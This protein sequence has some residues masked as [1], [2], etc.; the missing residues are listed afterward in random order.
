MT[1]PRILPLLLQAKITRFPKM[2]HLATLNHLD[3]WTPDAKA[4][5]AKSVLV[6]G[7]ELLLAPQVFQVGVKEV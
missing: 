5:V 1:G 4:E 7:D 3:D 2:F 6:S